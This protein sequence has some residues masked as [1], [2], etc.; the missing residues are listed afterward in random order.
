MLTGMFMNVNT[1]P[2]YSPL[3]FGF[4]PP[5]LLPVLSNLP[6]A[7]CKETDSNKLISVSCP[8]YVIIFGI[9][10]MNVFIAIYFWIAII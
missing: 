6:I 3:V 7:H 9:G 8:P 10:T 2:I 5:P 1:G 4:F